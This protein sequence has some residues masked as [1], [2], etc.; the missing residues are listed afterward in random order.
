[1]KVTVY[2]T[3]TCS[4]CVTLKRWLCDNEILFDDVYIDSDAK[5]MKEMIELSGQMSVP[6]MT[7]ESGEGGWQQVVGFDQAKLEA[8]FAV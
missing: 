4:Y 7:I 1:M 5:A 3:K 8:I 2:S 6:F